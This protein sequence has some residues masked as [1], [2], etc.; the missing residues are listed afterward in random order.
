MSKFTLGCVVASFVSLAAL[1]GVVTASQA[2]TAAPAK[3]G[4]EVYSAAE[5]KYVGVPCPAGTS[6]AAG[7][8]KPCGPEVY[9]A[10]EQ[11]YVGVPCTAPTPKVEAG[12]KAA[13]G[14]EVYSVAEQ[15][16]VGVPCSQ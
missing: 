6:T 1:A 5:Q 10:A 9:S 7:T 2:Q 8:D 11:K 4:T 12:Q 13:C 16:Y 14:T 15:K 3:C